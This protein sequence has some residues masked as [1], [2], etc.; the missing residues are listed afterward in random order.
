MRLAIRTIEQ[1]PPYRKAG[2]AAD[3]H[4]DD[5]LKGFAVR[6]YPS[7]R[8]SYLVQYRTR[9]GQTRRLSLGDVGI[10]TPTEA[11]D[12]AREHLASARKGFDPAA[13]RRN[14]RA[15]LTLAQ[16]AVQ[17]EATQA[18]RKRSWKDD[19]RCIERHILPAL[20][21]KKLSEITSPD[22]ER[23]Q[24]TLQAKAAA[25]PLRG[26]EKSAAEPRQRSRGGTLANAT[27]NRIIAVLK[28]MLSVAERDKLISSSPGRSVK[29]LRPAPPRDVVLSAEESSGIL[30]ACD[31]EPSAYAGGL[32]KTAL[33]TGRRIGELRVAKW[34][35]FDAARRL[36]QLPE[37]K[38][39][40]RQFAYL[41][42]SAVAVIEKLPKL[43]GNPFVFAGERPGQPLINYAKPFRRIL[44]RAG[45]SH[46]PV[47][48]LRH[49]AASQMIA[50]GV[51][52]KAVGGLLGHKD[53]RTTERYAHNR[54]LHL[55]AAADAL[56]LSIGQV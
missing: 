35:H 37:T 47:H 39:G 3:L 52:M 51:P 2:N 53:S 9:T 17:Y 45:V 22:I 42:A 28:H 12:L 49:N 19:K 24:R 36:L 40:E 32:I 10:L 15:E 43:E 1:L 21:G 27:V 56:E 54:A 50:S 29:M 4:F 34:E 26:R 23:L 16:F 48:G 20:G 33:L 7:G 6:V 30:S 41:N 55:H 14:A 18:H 13:E 25:Q 8:K 46:I 44:K 38:A 11:R 5:E 31:S